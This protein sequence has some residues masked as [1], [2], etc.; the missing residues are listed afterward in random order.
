[1]CG[2]TFIS[3]RQDGSCNGPINSHV[4]SDVER[5][6]VRD[7]GALDRSDSGLYSILLEWFNDMP[8]S[9]PFCLVRPIVQQ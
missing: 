7:V 4:A 2:L 6:D 3:R 8:C 9:K 5:L 1:M